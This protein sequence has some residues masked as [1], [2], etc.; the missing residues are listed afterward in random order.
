MNDMNDFNDLKKSILAKVCKNDK[1]AFKE[2]EQF[3]D[4]LEVSNDIG[5]KDGVDAPS[6]KYE[7]PTALLKLNEVQD[8][9]DLSTCIR[10]RETSM[11]NLKE[12]LRGLNELNTESTKQMKQ[13][14]KEM[15]EQIKQNMKQ[16]NQE[17]KENEKNIK[18]MK[19]SLSKLER[20][21][22]IKGPLTLYN[23][24]LSGNLGSFQ[25]EAP[26]DDFEDYS[27]DIE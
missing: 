10:I 25:E 14:I 22:R 11:E 9:L 16:I 19:R 2:F 5:S 13:K 20:I 4:S 12:S 7:T 15:K 23:E 3:F 26:F 21:I 8:Y 27:D 17:M 1:E 24:H 18:K 6:L